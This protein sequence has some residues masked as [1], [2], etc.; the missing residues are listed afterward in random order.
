[1]LD[2]AASL[3]DAFAVLGGDGAFA[4][5]ATRRDRPAGV[6]TKS[7]LLEYLAHHPTQ[8]PR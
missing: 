2:V 4:L 3:D 6:I 5:V 8:G 7:D 1:M